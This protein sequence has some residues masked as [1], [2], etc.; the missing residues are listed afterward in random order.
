MALAAAL[1][2]TITERE[3]LLISI[4]PSNMH[5]FINVDLT[6]RLQVPQSTQVEGK[7]V[8]IFEDLKITMDKYVF[9]SYFYTID[10]DDVDII[11]RHP[12]MG[13]VGTV[14]IDV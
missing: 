10:M 7:N 2:L 9:H 3:K 14:N 13:L 11:L 6:K 12:L 1:I 4:N 5:N 8:R